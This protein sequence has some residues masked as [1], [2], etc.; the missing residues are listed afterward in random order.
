MVAP[1]AG[2]LRI[3]LRTA[4]HLRWDPSLPPE[5]A[6]PDPGPD[7]GAF[8]VPGPTRIPARPRA[9]LSAGAAGT[10][11][12]ILDPDGLPRPRAV[13]MDG[14]G[15]RLDLPGPP[16]SLAPRA[17]GGVW[18][19]QRDGLH[20]VSAAGAVVSSVPMAGVRLLAAPG[21]G[22]WVLGLDAAWRVEDGGVVAGPDDW[23]DP[24][25]SCAWEG[26]LC[27]LERGGPPGVRCLD[28]TGGSTV[29]A[30]A[31]EP[32]PFERLVS[33]DGEAVLTATASRL[34][35][36]GA[37]GAMTELAMAGAGLTAAGDPFLATRDGEA[38]LLY[39]GGAPQRR[40]SPSAA[41][42]PADAS[43]LAV[44]GERVLLWAGDR[45]AWMAGETVE[46]AFEA[47]DASYA[48]EIF[49]HAWRADEPYP[50]VAGGDGA[51]LVAA[52]GPS[53]MAVL[54]I[55]APARS[56]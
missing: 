24:F 34:R 52:T 49:P 8:G 30:M 37:D 56:P 21:D 9:E 51:I 3:A 11:A 43:V 25:G 53:G 7:A 29:R 40:L 38:T 50:F 2:P 41:G 17:D 14:P 33:V 12:R 31:G 55:G 36:Y 1:V 10:V 28:A 6:V 45:A 20:H 22:V 39:A 32:G 19:L 44:D 26:R 35:R 27:R 15:T 13:W 48:A 5:A 16:L 42:L 47:T 18:S 23:R 46:R 4:A 54:E